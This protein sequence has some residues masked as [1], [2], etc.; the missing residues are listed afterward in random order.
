[1]RKT[2]SLRVAASVNGPPSYMQRWRVTANALESIAAQHCDSLLILDEL[3][4]VD[5]REAGDAAYM[6]A[7]ESSKARATR[8]G[9]ARP[10]LNWK[11]LFLSA[12]EVGLADH[13]AEAGRRP[14]AGQEARMVDIPADANC[15]LGIFEQL[16]GRPD[17]ATLANELQRAAATTYGA[18]GL[19]WLEWLQ[20]TGQNCAARC[21][22]GFPRFNP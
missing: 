6:L 13:L 12:G 11:L 3:A 9:G 5:P 2:S 7:N 20:P 22:K 8:N 10:R 15:G 16:H 17:A 14:R 18:P 1:L 4:Q 19:E 21:W